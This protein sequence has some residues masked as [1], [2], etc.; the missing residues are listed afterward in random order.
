MT[1]IRTDITSLEFRVALSLLT[2]FVKLA[3]SYHCDVAPLIGRTKPHQHS[4]GRGK[5]P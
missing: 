3:Q 1:K 4:L 2:V 5:R